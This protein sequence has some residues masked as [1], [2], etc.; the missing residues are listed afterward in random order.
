MSKYPQ[1]STKEI[2]TL[3]AQHY[4]PNVLPAPGD[5]ETR[6][7]HKNC[8]AI[9]PGI[10]VCPGHGRQM[11]R[12]CSISSRKKKETQTVNHWQHIPIRGWQANV[13][14][15]PARA[16]A[17]LVGKA[18]WKKRNARQFSWYQCT[19]AY[20]MLRAS[21]KDSKVSLGLVS[22]SGGHFDLHFS[23]KWIYCLLCQMLIVNS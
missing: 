10:S 7:A 4:K 15:V 2:V 9:S 1:F 5:S 20:Q 12:Q 23:S 8:D 3:Y 22:T 11:L 17:Y 13:S 18:H 21:G 19:R 16:Y 14:C 6:Q